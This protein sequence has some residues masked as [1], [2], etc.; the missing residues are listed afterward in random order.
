MTS[1]DNKV[2]KNNEVIKLNNQFEIQTPSLEDRTTSISTSNE[3]I[4]EDSK[5]LLIVDS[6]LRTSKHQERSINIKKHEKY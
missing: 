4:N 6:R 3:E 5:G 1:Y 2:L